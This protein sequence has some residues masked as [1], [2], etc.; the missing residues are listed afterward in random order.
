M[1]GAL[2]CFQWASYKDTV[3]DWI[4][5]PSGFREVHTVSGVLHGLRTWLSQIGARSYPRI[6]KHWAK[7]MWA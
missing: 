5:S 1:I 7:E 2:T 4:E 3:A 6:T